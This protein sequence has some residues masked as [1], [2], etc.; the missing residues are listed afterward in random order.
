MQNISNQFF[1]NN[2]A[3]PTAAK[4]YANNNDIGFAQMMIARNTGVDGLV[5]PMRPDVS[6]ALT[7]ALGGLVG[8]YGINVPPK[9]RIFSTKK[10]FKLEEGDERN[11]KFEML[12]NDH[13]GVSDLLAQAQTQALASREEAMQSAIETFTQGNSSGYD[14]KG[15]LTEFREQE[16][17][18]AISI[19]YDG[20]STQVE[21]SDGK[22]WRPIKNESDFMADLVKAYTRYSLTQAATEAHEAKGKTKTKNSLT[23]LPIDK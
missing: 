22:N 10:G 2:T 14:M 1:I 23:S 21:E 19:V 17:P 13:T 6:P 18:R 4:A 20:N 5:N 16:K 8:A 9:L 11:S 12:L 15:F 3:A 7:M